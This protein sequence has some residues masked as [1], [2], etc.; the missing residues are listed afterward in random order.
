MVKVTLHLIFQTIPFDQ[1]FFLHPPP[2]FLRPLTYDI[3][4]PA[5]CWKTAQSKIRGENAL[6]LAA[7]TLFS[8]LS[9]NLVLR[10]LSLVKWVRQP[11]HLHWYKKLKSQQGR[12]R[13]YEVS[14]TGGLPRATIAASKAGFCHMLYFSN[15]LPIWCPESVSSISIR[16]APSK[17]K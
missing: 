9:I 7:S 8:E 15:E 13:L 10:I 4:F 16:T 6:H 14:H 17:S 2:P 12:V 1:D 11:F 3:I 5:K